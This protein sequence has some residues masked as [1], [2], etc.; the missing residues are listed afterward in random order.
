LAFEEPLNR[1]LLILRDPQ[2]RLRARRAH[3]PGHD[4][5][6][7]WLRDLP[8]SRGQIHVPIEMVVDQ[9]IDAPGEIGHSRSYSL[10]HNE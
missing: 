8:G 4:A 7:R 2:Q 10:T 6:K 1:R 3:F 5:M 9:L